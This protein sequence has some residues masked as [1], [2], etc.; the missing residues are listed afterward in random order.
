VQLNAIADQ[1]AVGSEF[2]LLKLR[3]LLDEDCDSER[4]GRPKIKH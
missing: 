3:N 4:L 1:P 2:H